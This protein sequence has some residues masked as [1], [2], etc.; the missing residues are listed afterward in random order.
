MDERVGR[1]I[2][3]LEVLVIGLPT[4]ALAIPTL[5]LGVV[6]TVAAMATSGPAA[7]W[8]LVTSGSS[9]DAAQVAA[10]LALIVGGIVGLASWFVLSGL[11]LSG[12]RAALREVGGHWW[13]AL[14]AGVA[15]VVGLLCWM[16]WDEIR[17]L[18][19]SW[20]L[21]PALVLPALHLFYLRLRSPR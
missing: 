8:E 21:G 5:F 6:L 1:W 12:G 13:F 3:A 7:W 15:V 20:F 17:K 16:G 19:L 14:A 18:R 2:Y 9:Q 11:Y 4:L 10:W